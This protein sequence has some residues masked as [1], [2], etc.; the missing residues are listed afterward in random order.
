MKTVNLIVV[1]KLKNKHLEAIEKD[2]SDRIQSP[3]FI[4]HEVKA[5][6][7]NVN[8]EALNVLKKIQDIDSKTRSKIY[9]LAENGKEY[10]SHEFSK[11]IFKN[12]EVHDSIIFIIAGAHGHGEEVLAKI[13][14]KISLSKLTFPHKIARIV[15]V[16]QLYRAITIKTAHPYH[17]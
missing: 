6:A 1:G 16:E 12:I 11:F 4:T 10:D 5:S 15:F 2:Y 13:D 14:G 3:K 8:I 7:E 17:N 9:A